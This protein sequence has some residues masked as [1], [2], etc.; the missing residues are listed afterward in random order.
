MFTWVPHGC[1]EG[2]TPERKQTG[3]NWE[4]VTGGYERKQ[5]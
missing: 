5:V 3:L 2:K 4:R 1:R